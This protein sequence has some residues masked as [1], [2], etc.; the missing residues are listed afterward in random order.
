MRGNIAYEYC[1]EQYSIEYVCKTTDIKYYKSVACSAG[2][3]RRMSLILPPALSARGVRYGALESVCAH[4]LQF[5][6]R[7]T[8]TRSRRSG[9]ACATGIGR[10]IRPR[11]G[12]VG[13][14]DSR[15]SRDTKI[16]SGYSTN[17]PANGA[18]FR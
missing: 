8:H 13:R 4:L 18:R 7:A 5:A 10:R 2:E 15:N 17:Y 1:A 12:R 14:R 6:D 3:L 11:A 16:E 9:E